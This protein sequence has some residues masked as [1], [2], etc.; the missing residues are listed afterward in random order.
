MLHNKNNT[1]IE[2]VFTKFLVQKTVQVN[3]I[4]Y[5]ETPGHLTI[6]SFSGI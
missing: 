3:I 4:N 5:F 6:V 2:I 1:S